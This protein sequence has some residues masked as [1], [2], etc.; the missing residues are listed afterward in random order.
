MGEIEHFIDPLD[1]SHCKFSLIA[2]D[3]LPLWTAAAQEVN[4][5]I[6]KDMTLCQAL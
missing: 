2:D 6:I 3:M 4:G 5:P 1:K